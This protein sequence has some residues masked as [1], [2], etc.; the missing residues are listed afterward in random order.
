MKLVVNKNLCIGCG[1]CVSLCGDVFEFDK[2]NKSQVK[3]QADLKKNANC[4][5][6]AIDSCPVQAISEE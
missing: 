6:Q 1:S 2:D 3:P 4:V 5:K